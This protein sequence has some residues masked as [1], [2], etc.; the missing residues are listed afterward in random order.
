MLRIGLIVG[1]TRPN[2]F[3]DTPA[4]WV[5]AAAAQRTDLAIRTLDLREEDLPFFSEAAPPAETNGVFA[6][7]KAE[8]WRSKL[9]DMDG[10]IVTVAEYNHGPTAVLKN[11]IDSA[12]LEWLRKPI[13]FVG[14]GGAGGVRAVQQLR[15][16]VIGLEMAPIKQSVV[17][18]ADVYLAARQGKPLEDFSHLVQAR[19]AMLDSLAWWAEAL[20]RAREA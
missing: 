17:I 15:T 12:Y 8:L 14:Y 16:T 6:S 5:T 2:R 10:F 1:S 9:A 4:Q 18:S 11:A 20:K 19:D 13:A 3:A 7:P